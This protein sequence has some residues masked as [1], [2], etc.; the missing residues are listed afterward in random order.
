MSLVEDYHQHF[1]HAIATSPMAVL[2]HGPSIEKLEKYIGQL[3]DKDILYVSLNN[4]HVVEQNILN[5]INRKVDIWCCLSP[6]IA[7]TY[8]KEVIDFLS[9]DSSI[10]LLTNSAALD[11]IKQLASISLLP[12]SH[13]I[14]LT[15][16]IEE[17]T[18]LALRQLFP[19]LGDSSG[20]F[21]TLFFI[22]CFILSYR[23]QNIY[24]FGCDGLLLPSKFL[25]T[26]NVYYQQQ[27]VTKKY[28]TMSGVHFDRL[29]FDKHW[30]AISK[31]V[32]SVKNITNVINVNPNSHYQAFPK[33]DIQQ[34]ISGFTKQPIQHNPVK[35]FFRRLL[36]N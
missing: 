32:L 27:N 31:E 20:L 21:N 22:L 15:D 6:D 16:Q 23:Q 33:I 25:P 14:Y 4:K 11:I 2:L 3:R 17:K 35:H 7:K 12:N 5:K 18:R 10:A 9:D 19:K 29:F 13:K 1:I 26:Q 8:Y 30:P 36:K 28:V 34:A 24:L